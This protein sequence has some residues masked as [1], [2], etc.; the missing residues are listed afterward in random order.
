MGKW[1]WSRDLVSSIEILE[2]NELISQLDMVTM[3]GGK[4]EWK[5]MGNKSDK[6]SV[7]SVIELMCMEKDYSQLFVMRRSK[8]VPK[9]LDALIKRNINVEDQ[10]CV[11]CDHET[12]TIEHLLTG[13]YIA[14][15]VWHFIGAW[16][17]KGSFFPFSVK[18]LLCSTECYCSNEKEKEAFHG[19]IMV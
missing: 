10:R 11:F 12:E 17:L 15:V 9:K 7:S 2:W 13:C 16:C 6:F 18:D 5:W 1:S 14:A 3:S 19:V 4:D 8:W